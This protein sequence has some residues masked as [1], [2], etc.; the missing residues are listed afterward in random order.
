MA[1][2]G[3]HPLLGENLYSWVVGVRCEEGGS[4]AVGIVQVLIPSFV[5]W[6]RRVGG[7]VLFWVSS[8]NT[9]PYNCTTV[10]LTHV[11]H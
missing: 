3:V 11:S 10:I 5:D 4:K 8:S 2:L 9:P 6:D 1:I 7:F